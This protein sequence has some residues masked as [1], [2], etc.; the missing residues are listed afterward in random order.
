VTWLQSKLA[1]QIR[2]GHAF[3]SSNPTKKVLRRV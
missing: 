3:L 1:N 2:F